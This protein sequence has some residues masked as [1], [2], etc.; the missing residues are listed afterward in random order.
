MARHCC[1]HPLVCEMYVEISVVLPIG[2]W[3]LPTLRHSSLLTSWL[4]AESRNGFVLA[5]PVKA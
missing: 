5:G 4:L 1:S 3:S 2:I